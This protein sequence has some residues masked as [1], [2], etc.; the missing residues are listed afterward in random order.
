MQFTWTS[1]EWCRIFSDTPELFIL[2][3]LNQ[4]GKDG[5]LKCRSAH[6]GTIWIQPPAYTSQVGIEILRVSTSI[7]HTVTFLNTK[8]SGSKQF[9]S[10]HVDF[11]FFRV[12]SGS[13]LLMLLWGAATLLSFISQYLGILKLEQ[14]LRL[15]DKKYTVRIYLNSW[16]VQTEGHSVISKLQRGRLPPFHK[17]YIS[18]EW[19]SQLFCLLTLK[20]IRTITAIIQIC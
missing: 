18:Q 10:C 8:I 19:M 4:W 14:C 11:L 1:P 20:R 3:S 15:Y 9:R 12:A 6:A 13:F 5:P 16:A 2:W 7:V 17:S